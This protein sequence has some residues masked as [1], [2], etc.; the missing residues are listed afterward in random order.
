MLS[1]AGW[2]LRMTWFLLLTLL[3]R[4]GRGSCRNR[5]MCRCC[6]HGRDFWRCL[7]QD[8]VS[9]LDPSP[10]YEITSTYQRDGAYGRARSAAGNGEGGSKINPKVP[11]L[12]VG[13]AVHVGGERDMVVRLRL[14]HT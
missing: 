1:P 11:A 6:W 12:L 10:K 9:Q 3:L 4:R 7:L 5:L 8:I 14:R 13:P 2:W